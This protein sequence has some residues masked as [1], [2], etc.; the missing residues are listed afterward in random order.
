MAADGSDQVNVAQVPH[1]IER[2]ATWSPDS[3]LLAFSGVEGPVISSLDGTQ[4]HVL[5]APQGLRSPD[6]SPDGAL[7]AYSRQLTPSPNYTYEIHVVGVDDTGPFVLGPGHSPEWQ[8]VAQPAP[9]TLRAHRPGWGLLSVT[10]RATLLDEAG[11]PVAGRS[12]RFTAGSNHLCSATTD[13]AGV[14]TCP[15]DLLGWLAVLLGAGYQ[16][17]FAGDTAY[18]PATGRTT[19]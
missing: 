17:S 13:A 5:H 1:M 19:S 9:T 14:A 16:A 6:W 15:T 2:D 3:R 11:T 18:R 4:R 10:T 12:V 7:I 8:P